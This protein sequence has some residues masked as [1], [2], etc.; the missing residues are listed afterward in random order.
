[1]KINHIGYLEEKTTSSVVCATGGQM[2]LFS[3][4]VN[5]GKR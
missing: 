4:L 5:M 3:G 1:M 2:R